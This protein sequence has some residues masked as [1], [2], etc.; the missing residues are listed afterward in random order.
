ML[1]GLISGLFWIL[2]FSV[3]AQPGKIEGRVKNG[4]MP[5]SFVSVGIKKS[6]IGAVT[7]KYGY[8]LLND[9]QPGT[10]AISFSLVGYSSIDTVVVLSMG[11]TLNL[12]INMN[13]QVKSL[14]EVVITGTMREVNRAESPVPVDIISPKFFQKNPTPSLFESV[15]MINGVQPQINCNVCNTGDIHINGMEGPYTMILIDG[16]PIVS[17]L[18]SVYGLSGIPNSMV[19]RIEVVK[20]PA[21]SLYGSEA[22]GGIIN[23]ITKSA[24]KSPV[25]SFDLFT[26]SWLEHSA[27]LSAKISKGKNHGL[28]GVNYF[29]YNNPIDNNDDGFTDV[30][31]QD[32]ISVFNKW[33]FGRPSGKVAS[34]AGRFVYED[35]WGGQMNW[36]REFR[37]TDS[38]YGESIYTARYELVG[39][40]QLPLKEKVFSQWSY[41]WHRQN[42][43][44]GTTS[45]NAL[46]PVAFGQV[47]LDKSLGKDKKHNFLGGLSMRYTY[48]DDNSITTLSEDGL[49]NTPVHTP[50]PGV[51]VQDEWTL[52]HKHRLLTGYRF[53]YDKNHG[54]VHSPRIAYKLTLNKNNILRLSSGTGFRVVNLFTEDHAA[55]TGSR[56]VQIIEDLDPERSLNANLNF[57]KTIP[58][59]NLFAGFDASLFYS[60]YSN[61][62]IA[63]LDSDYDKIIYRNLNGHA[64]SRGVSFNAD[65]SLLI[66]IKILLG[67][68]YM[69]VFNI[70]LD[71]HF[72]E[73]KE[74]QLFAPEWSGNFVITYSAPTGLVFDITGK[75]NGPMRLPVF[76]NDFRPNFSP[77]FCVANFQLTKKTKRNLEIYA[78][79]KNIFDFVPQNPLMRPHDPFDKMINDPAD[80]PDNYTFET[81]YN[82]S[83]LQG[84]RAFGGIR[85][86]IGG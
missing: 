78:G 62:I 47:Y 42:S 27:D 73:I 66:P 5:V 30:T 67:V 76:E 44:Y 65:F 7:D 75:V 9:I 4:N 8:F 14:D 18:S 55:L 35:R 83:A 58:G 41:T 33:D 49:T 19:E 38:V 22:M 51:F 40:Y 46:Q 43:F 59:Q 72:Q 12:E 20:G 53:D 63:D 57:V 36:K 25:F 85:Y 56:E 84:I 3:H 11:E 26:T 71:E 60:Y 28:L 50:I 15:G 45:F 32:R 80:N 74:R 81:T 61:K 24:L 13:Q 34:L 70:E 2:L 10:H 77:W 69:D 6:G 86:R 17:S 68:T 52:S 39:T 48:Y 29:N 37:G 16:M 54:T 82:Y 1:R 64:V 31:L 79:V 21:S 23:V